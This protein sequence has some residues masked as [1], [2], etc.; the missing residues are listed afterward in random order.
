MPQGSVLGPLLFN[1]YIN[2]LF[3][4]FAEVCNF[5][6]DTTL[7]ASNLDLETLIQN[8]EDDSLKA[9]LW[10][11]NNYMKLN[12]E[13]CHFLVSGGARGMERGERNAGNGT[14]GMERGEWIH[15][16]WIRGESVPAFHS[17]D[18]IPRVPWNAFQTRHETFPALTFHVLHIGGGSIC[19]SGNGNETIHQIELR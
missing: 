13:K 11:E 9:I 12:D 6:D 4:Q 3:F 18:S 15:G 2:D 10:F 19:K 1:I 14:W 7:Y 17:P 16:E 8:L 5:A